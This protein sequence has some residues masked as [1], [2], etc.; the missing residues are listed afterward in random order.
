MTLS[1]RPSQSVLSPCPSDAA[2]TSWKW[3]P[4]KALRASW[5]HFS[6]SHNENSQSNSQLTDACTPVASSFGVKNTTSPRQECP[7]TSSTTSSV[8]NDV[9]STA[10]VSRKLRSHVT[11]SDSLLYFS[12][13]SESDVLFGSPKNQFDVT[14]SNGI[15]GSSQVRVMECVPQPECSISS[16]PQPS[17]PG[18]INT[19]YEMRR[20]EFLR[21]LKDAG[22]RG[23]VDGCWALWN[24]V[25]RPD[26]TFQ[27]CEVTLGLMVDSLINCGC[28]CDAELLVVNMRGLIKPNTVIYSSLIDGWGR[29]R[30]SERALAVFR[31][32][33][34]DG[35]IC[36]VITFNC[37]MSACVRGGALDAAMGLLWT[38]VQAGVP[39]LMPDRCSFSTVIQGFCA[40]SKVR[41][42]LQLVDFMVKSAKLLPDLVLLNI[43]LNGCVK[44]GLYRLFDSLLDS[45]TKKYS[46]IPNCYTL[47]IV[48][49]R[50]TR[51]RQLS[52]GFLA[53]ER[54]CS[55]YSIV[56]NTHV[57]TCLMSACMSQGHQD[58]AMLMFNSLKD[59]TKSFP[60]TGPISPSLLSLT[61]QSDLDAKAYQT[62]VSGLRKN[63][64]RKLAAVL[65]QECLSVFH[66]DRMS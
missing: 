20:S 43:L 21:Q 51:T 50:Y 42:A 32:M 62:V 39:S 64:D 36:N 17:A 63:G 3:S 23:D 13:V 10:S 18:R 33:V 22:R 9:S 30:N 34:A 8:L 28:V 12:A 16:D 1:G 49:M 58:L 24:L 44:S 15:D 29:A 52:E 59:H 47:S 37:L 11:E 2:V 56:P 40:A 31:T 60:A 5:S 7:W 46:I 45:M 26:S 41:Q 19:S 57:W 65:E 54:L 61:S 53:V 55:T 35:V 38:M 27:I 14:V 25:T 66:K 48:V 6:T 4:G